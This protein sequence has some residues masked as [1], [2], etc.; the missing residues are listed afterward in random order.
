MKRPAGA[1][2]KHLEAAEAWLHLGNHV[3]AEGELESIAADLSADPEVLSVRWEICAA[4][5]RWDAALKVALTIVAT[6][7]KRTKNWLR[8]SQSLRELRRFIEARANIRLARES[9]DWAVD[10][11][12]DLASEAAHLDDPE[13]ALACL[14]ASTGK[15]GFAQ[16]KALVLATDVFKKIHPQIRVLSY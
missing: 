4:A 9:N 8:K 3:E 5:K 16:L 6:N 15:A 12:Y 13:E 1:D 2:R 10:D 7:P 11:L 14:I